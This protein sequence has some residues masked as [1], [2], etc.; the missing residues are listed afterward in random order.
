MPQ[1]Y[2]QDWAE[3]RGL[4]AATSEDDGGRAGREASLWDDKRILFVTW[5]QDREI[6]QGW[7]TF[8]SRR[9][10]KRRHTGFHDISLLVRGPHMSG[11]L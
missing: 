3:R 8:M 2:W 4:D 7:E 6:A 11:T 9:N 10:S 5:S 1:E